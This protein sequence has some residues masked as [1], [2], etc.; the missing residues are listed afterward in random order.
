M[1]Y[2]HNVNELNILLESKSE[3]SLENSN[4]IKL[5]TKE[6]QQPTGLHRKISVKFKKLVTYG[7]WEL[8]T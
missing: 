3:E 5:K 2:M 8:G 7:L 6:I 1:S 4:L